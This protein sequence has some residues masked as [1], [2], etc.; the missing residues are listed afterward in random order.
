[1]RLPIKAYDLVVVG[2]GAAGFSALVKFTELTGGEGQIALVTQGPL[3]GTCV[4]TG[5]VPSKYLIET[6][7]VLKAARVAQERGIALGDPKIDF[8]RVMQGA[9]DLV[10]SLRQGKYEALLD[11]YPNVTLYRGRARFTGPRTIQVEG[12]QKAAVEGRHLLIATGSRPLVP[13]IE[14]LERVS[15]HT[16]DTIWGLSERPGRL[17][18]VGAGA[19][20]LELAQV[21]AR[22]GVEV[23]VVEVLD[24]PI[25]TTEP[26][27]S[28]ELARVM[29]EEGVRFLFKSRVSSLRERNGQVEAEMVGPAGTRRQ[30]YDLVLVATGRRPNSDNLGLEAAGVKTDA[31]GYIQVGQD[32]KTTNPH[33]YAAGDVA[34][35]PKPALLETLAA[36]EGAVAAE[37]IVRNG[38]KSID[39][40][41]VPVVVFTDPELAYVG[42]TERAVIEQL[43][44]CSCR[45]VRFKDLPRAGIVGVEE[46]LAK[47]ILD[48]RTGTIEGIHLLAPNAS[49]YVVGAALLVKHRYTVEQLLDLVHAFPTSAELVK[50]AAQAFLRRPEEMPCCVE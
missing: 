40:R 24:R 46:G 37:N 13:P 20:G 25:P 50:L 47:L 45:T 11:R 17:L 26:E 48:P 12:E 41:S 29:A 14:G 28:Q 36:K 10:K 8:P 35:S 23:E 3:G 2:G 49:E 16:T 43:G 42:L 4:N 39:Y 44:A 19:V 33:I 5:C 32:L 30:E 38:G 18:M 15:Y 34:G 1:M 6:C 7:K 22:L 21:F 31:K 27:L 9:R